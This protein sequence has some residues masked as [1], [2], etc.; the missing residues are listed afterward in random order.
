MGFVKRSM[1]TVGVTAGLL[2]LVTACSGAGSATGA[3]QATE[4]TFKGRCVDAKGEGIPAFSLAVGRASDPQPVAKTVKTKKGQFTT[5]LSISPPAATG[6]KV[7]GSRNEKVTINVSADGY[8]GKSFTV[9]AD[10]VFVGQA[11]TLNVT[12]EPAPAS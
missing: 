5:R 8:K 11:N 1:P 12:L 9:T 7:L 6:D 2:L 3:K 4:L 10:K